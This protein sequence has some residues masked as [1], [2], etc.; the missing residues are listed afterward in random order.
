VLAQPRRTLFQKRRSHELHRNSHIEFPSSTWLVVHQ[1][2]VAPVLGRCHNPRLV[3]S[4][5][6]CDA[7]RHGTSACGG[8]SRWRKQSEMRQREKLVNANFCAKASPNHIRNIM[9]ASLWSDACLVARNRPLQTQIDAAYT[10]CGIT[11]GNIR[12][13]LMPLLLVAFIA[14]A[15]LSSYT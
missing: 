11:V 2:G 12:R 5:H 13:F 6:H 7:Q 15:F 8:A 10:S 14:A 9:S 1:R 4:N 3:C